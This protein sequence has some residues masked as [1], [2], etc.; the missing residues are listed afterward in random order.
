MLLTT[1]ELVMGKDDVARLGSLK[2]EYLVV[3]E[4]HRLKNAASR[5]RAQLKQLRY[6]HIL[7]LTG[8]WWSPCAGHPGSDAAL[9]SWP[10]EVGFLS[11]PAD[12]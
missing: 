10:A 6:K 2:W 12:L 5:L 9:L 11:R 3:D 7:L 1:Y 8:G 4:A